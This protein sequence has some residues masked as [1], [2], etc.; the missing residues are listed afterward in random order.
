MYIICI[1]QFFLVTQQLISLDE[2]FMTPY[3]WRLLSLNDYLITATI[4]I[5]IIVTAE[6]ELFCSF[7]T[8]DQNLKYFHFTLLYSQV[9]L[10]KYS[11]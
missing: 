5:F 10:P 2:S 1:T 8:T 7:H 6:T 3:S 9:L 4:H 11:L